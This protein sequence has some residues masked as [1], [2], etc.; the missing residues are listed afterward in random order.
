MVGDNHRT[1]AGGH[2]HILRLSLLLADMPGDSG[3]K[4]SSDRG[5]RPSSG[6]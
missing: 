4:P 2:A 3:D 6:P 1:R 5:S